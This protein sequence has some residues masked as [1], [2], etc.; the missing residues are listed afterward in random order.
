MG[1]FISHHL[2]W[3]EN[4]SAIHYV[5]ASTY[6]NSIISG[7]IAA[8]FSVRDAYTYITKNPKKDARA[9]LSIMHGRKPA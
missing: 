6:C 1:R 3:M 7:E 4:K 8:H 5:H 9:S 2:F